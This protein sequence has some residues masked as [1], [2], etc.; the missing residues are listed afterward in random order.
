MPPHLDQHFP[1]LLKVRREICFHLQIFNGQKGGHW[2]DNV[3]S[4]INI[5]RWDGNLSE[6]KASTSAF[7]HAKTSPSIAQQDCLSNSY[8]GSRQ[9]ILSRGKTVAWASSRLPVDKETLIS[10]GL[11]FRPGAKRHLCI[12][13]QR[14]SYRQPLCL[15]LWL[16]ETTLC[17]NKCL[18]TDLQAKQFV[19]FFFFFINWHWNFTH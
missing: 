16:P 5:I 2:L 1:Q 18:P 15:K 4:Q 9:S 13:D 12:Q 19:G 7:F 11:L 6:R 14:R 10:K 8:P 3:T 17:G